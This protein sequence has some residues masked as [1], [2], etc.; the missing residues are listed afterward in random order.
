[1]SEKDRKHVAKEQVRDGC[2]DP[3]VVDVPNPNKMV[4]ND[5]ITR[6]TGDGTM[7]QGNHKP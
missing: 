4:V 2:R 3:E 5:P 6:G 7:H 1:M